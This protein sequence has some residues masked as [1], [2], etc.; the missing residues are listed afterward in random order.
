MLTFRNRSRP[1][2]RAVRPRQATLRLESLET[3][4][5]L[6][7]LPTAAL[8]ASPLGEAVTELTR[9]VPEVINSSGY[10]PSDREKGPA[11]LTDTPYLPELP[12]KTDPVVTGPVGMVPISQAFPVKE[13][14]GGVSALGILPDRGNSLAPALASVADGLVAP[15]RGGGGRDPLEG[16]SSLSE[17]FL[18]DLLIAGFSGSLGS[19]NWWTFTGEVQ[20]LNP[21]YCT[22]TFGGDFSQLT[23]RSTATQLTGGRYTFALAVQLPSTASGWVTAQATDL[24]TGQTSNLAR[25]WVA[26]AG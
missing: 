22:V 3:R 19:G 21:Q 12:A 16:T 2:Q 15:A 11:K 13:P 4:D 20:G 8:M 1:V 14:S 7:A 9:H 17:G 26:P 10:T 25:Y 5:Y 24:L 23:G 6:A 18:A